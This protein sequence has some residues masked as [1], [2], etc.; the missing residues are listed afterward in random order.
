[1]PLKIQQI[2]GNI[3]LEFLISGNIL[4]HMTA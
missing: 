4:I 2:N 3:T 1:M